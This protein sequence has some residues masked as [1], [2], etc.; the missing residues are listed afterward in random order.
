MEILMEVLTCCQSKL[1][2]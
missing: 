1:K 2:L